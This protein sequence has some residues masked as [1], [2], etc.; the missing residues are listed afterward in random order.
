MGRPGPISAAAEVVG[1]VNLALIALRLPATLFGLGWLTTVFVL[2][3]SPLGTLLGVVGSQR[4]RDGASRR[5]AR[6]AI[7][8][9]G[10]AF[11]VHVFLLLLLGP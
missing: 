1:L 5:A 8:R 10:A 7:L 11:A 9:S 4:E 6:R 2:I 3:T